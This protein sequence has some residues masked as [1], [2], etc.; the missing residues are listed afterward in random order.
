MNR[1]S[2]LLVGHDASRTG[3]PIVQLSTLRW[4]V[5]R[6]V[7]ARTVLVR[8][9]PLV[10]DFSALAPC[11]VLSS[12]W[13]RAVEAVGAGLRSVGRTVT[14]PDRALHPTPVRSAR[15]D[16]VVAN[17]LAALPTAVWLTRRSG[18]GTTLVCH[19]HELDGA[20]QRLL[21]PG[22]DDRQELLGAVDRFIATGACVADMLI[23]RLGVPP[24]KVEVVEAFI[25]APRVAPDRVR[26]VADR[27]RAGSARPIVLDSGAMIRRKGP[28]R[29]VDLMEM[30]VS[31]HTRP[32]GV[33]LGGAADGPVRAEVLADVQ[34]AALEGALTVVAEVPDPLVHLAAADVVVSTAIE[35]PY[36][37]AVLESA[38]LGVPVV[39]FESGGLAEV[40]QGAGAASSVVGVGDLL[41]MRD[42]VE[43]LLEDP[44]L[45]QELGSA[46]SDLVRERH[47]TERVVPRWW[48]AVSA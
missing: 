11:T 26:Q 13:S 36:P 21:P 22:A 42:R 18:R 31:H 44:G 35:D 3:A 47:L 16:I 29:F 27:W 37:L 20:A 7:D 25:D 32:L 34:R 12:R 23:G 43:Q 46:L 2:I 30:L 24:G 1:P 38:A 8:G 40:L 28:E 4:L 39:G 17:T 10:D 33:W 41:G 5:G 6:G 14:V 45:A 9:G 48:A 15:A 19:V